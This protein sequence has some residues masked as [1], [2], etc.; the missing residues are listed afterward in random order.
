MQ[1]ALLDI[2]Q[3][4]LQKC[5]AFRFILQTQVTQFRHLLLHFL[6]V[7]SSERDSS[8]RR[9]DRQN[10]EDQTDDPAGGHGG[11]QTSNE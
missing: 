7:V 9:E 3:D 10:D 4:L 1:A 8:S 11:I 6:F 2:A 5:V